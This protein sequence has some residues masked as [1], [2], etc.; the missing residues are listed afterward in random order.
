MISAWHLIWIIPLSVGVGM[1]YTA[2][3][4][5]TGRSDKTEDELWEALKSQSTKMDK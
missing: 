1:F 5:T 4:V 3:A 2:L